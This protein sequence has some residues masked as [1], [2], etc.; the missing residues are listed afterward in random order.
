MLGLL[1]RD[2]WQWPF[3]DINSSC[4]IPARDKDGFRTKYNH[5]SSSCVDLE[6]EK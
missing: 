1:V 4:I 6:T 2:E 3:L 5:S